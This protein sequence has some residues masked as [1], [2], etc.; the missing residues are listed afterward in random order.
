MRRICAADAAG[1][2]GRHGGVRWAMAAVEGG[3]GARYG[4]RCR[5][6]G[7]RAARAPPSD[8][9]GWHCR[10]RRLRDLFQP[11]R[12]WDGF[13][14]RAHRNACTQSDR[15]SPDGPWEISG[16]RWAPAELLGATWGGGG[17]L[18]TS[19]TVRPRDE[20]ALLR[21]GHDQGEEALTAGRWQGENT[22][23]AAGGGSESPLCKAGGGEQTDARPVSPPS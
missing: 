6:G 10:W 9:G 7:G 4:N 15:R 2:K 21:E 8:G 18:I 19:A 14:P 13:V 16:P 3:G 17:K 5:G 11:R 12:P 22:A 20:S 1:E 23:G